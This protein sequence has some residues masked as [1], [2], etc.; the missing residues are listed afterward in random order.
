MDATIR[1][2]KDNPLLVKQTSQFRVLLKIGKS[3]GLPCILNERRTDGSMNER[4]IWHRSHGWLAT[5]SWSTRS[6]NYHRCRCSLC[7]GISALSRTDWLWVL[8]SVNQLGN[9]HPIFTT[10]NSN[11]PYHLALQRAGYWHI[12]SWFDTLYFSLHNNTHL[13]H[14]R[15]IAYP[16][17]LIGPCNRKCTT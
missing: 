9:R 14:S 8:Q 16:S 17:P 12:T 15:R 10:Y 5:S 7:F 13:I 1:L 4:L 2:W 6:L 11:H 3:H